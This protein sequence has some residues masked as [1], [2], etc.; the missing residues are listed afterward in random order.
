MMRM[1]FK[2]AFVAHAPDANP[3]ENKALIETEKYKLFVYVVSNQG[4]AIEVCKGLVE[5]EGIQSILLCPGFSHQDIAQ[6]CEAVGPDVGIGVARTVIAR[7]W[8]TV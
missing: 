8:G 3:E 5:R 2:A 6:I 1:A 7:E 4:E